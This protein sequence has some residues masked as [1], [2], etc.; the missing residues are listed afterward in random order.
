ME[1]RPIDV[2]EFVRGFDAQQRPDVDLCAL[3]PGDILVIATVNT[4]YRI[5]MEDSR[6]GTMST[7]RTMRPVGMVQLMGS[8]VGL[9]AAIK[10]DGVFC[11]GS[12]EYLH[13]ATNRVHVTT[14][15]NGIWLINRL[16]IN[17]ASSPE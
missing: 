4:V 1:T 7:N 11:G 6:S 5:V 9:S 12:L 8:T 14:A 13:R 10:P 2:A 16:P 17:S 3:R 15:I